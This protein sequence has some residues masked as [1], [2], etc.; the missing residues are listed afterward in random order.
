MDYDRMKEKIPHGN[1]M[2]PLMVHEID[3]DIQFSERL[4]CHWHNEIEF[5]VVTKGEA[6]FHINERTYHVKQGDVLL[7][8]SN[9]LHSASAIDDLPFQFFAIVF[10]ASLLDSCLNDGIQQKYLTPVYNKSILLQEY[11]PPL[12]DWIQ[13]IH[14]LLYEIR[15]LYEKQ[16]VCFELQIKSNLFQI[17]SLLFTHADASAN[18]EQKEN[19]Y[20]ITRL[21]SV[22]TYIHENYSSKITLHELSSIMGLCEGQFCRFFKSMT[23]MSAMDYVNHY[24]ITQSIA[25][26][27]TTDKSIS[28]IAGLCGY[29]NISYFNKIFL[30]YMHETPTS[31]RKSRA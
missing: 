6:E 26:I 31:Y 7:V 4:N 16:P 14:D 1:A 9:L 24:R 8:H 2:F 15:E 28:E 27:T 29:N 3:T 17:W 13:K 19:D 21:K 25:L 18:L 11:L 10:Q 23:R 12:T 30:K 20:R 22:M 5:F